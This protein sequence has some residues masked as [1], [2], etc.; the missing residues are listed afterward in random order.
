[1]RLRNGRLKNPKPESAV[2]KLTL[3]AGK[4]AQVALSPKPRFAARVASQSQVFVKRTRVMRGRARTDF[5]R[6]AF[7]D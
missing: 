4:S 2:V 5:P 3:P 1:M 6:L 7:V